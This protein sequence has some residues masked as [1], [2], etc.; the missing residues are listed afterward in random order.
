MG[1]KEHEV[2]RDEFE[3]DS[4]SQEFCFPCCACKH[5]TQSQEEEPCCNCDH[6]ANAVK[7]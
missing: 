6:N 3:F 1:L 2:S 4:D 5:V 7:P